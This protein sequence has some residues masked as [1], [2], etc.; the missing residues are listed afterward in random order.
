MTKNAKNY[1]PK[2]GAY[3][4]TCTATGERYV[5]GSVDMSKRINSHLSALRCGSHSNPRMQERYNEHGPD[6]FVCK[7]LEK[8]SPEQVLSVEQK[9]LDIIKPEFNEYAQADPR[10]RIASENVLENM[11]K[12]QRPNAIGNQFAKGAVRSPETRAKI[13][14]AKRGVPS[15]LRGRKLSAE[16]KAKI[17]AAKARC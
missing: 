16:H 5:G 1:S 4:I 11:R 17:S 12:A 3:L 6:K 9:W 15:K 10:G 7:Y 13:G 2:S 14:A 8:C